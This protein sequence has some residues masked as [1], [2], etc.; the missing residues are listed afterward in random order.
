MEIKGPRIPKVILK[1]NKVGWLSLSDFKTY[2]DSHCNRD[3]VVLAKGT[4]S[5]EQKKKSKYRPSDIWSIDFQWR[6]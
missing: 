2:Y 6:C 1:K 3:S 5:M 4:T